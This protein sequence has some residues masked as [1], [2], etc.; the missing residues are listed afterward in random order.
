MP[1]PNR[2]PGAL[3]PVDALV[4]ERL[5][6]P[7][8]DVGAGRDVRRLGGVRED[9]PGKVGD[10]DV[11]ARRAEV[12]DEQMPGVGAEADGPRRAAPG[13]RADAALGDEPVVGERGQPLADQRP[14][15]PGR[16]DEL[17]RACTC[18]GGARSRGSRQDPA[19]TPE[20]RDGTGLAIVASAYS[21]HRRHRVTYADIP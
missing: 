1:M 20:R 4:E 5:D 2:A 21:Q 15:E 10:G 11:D 7:E 12:G 19:G 3:H 16:L 17:A 9:L 18:R 13:R 14:A 8:H 6:A